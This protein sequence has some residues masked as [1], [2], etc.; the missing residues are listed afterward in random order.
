[1]DMRSP[2]F[3]PALV[4]GLLA[5]APGAAP[6]WNRPGH[7]VSAAI[8][9]QVLKADDP[10]TI[11]KAALLREHPYYER[12]W[13][14]RLEGVAPEDRDLVLFMEAARWPDDARNDEKFHH[15]EWHYV[16]LPFKP[17]GQPDR[18]RPAGPDPTNILWAFPRQLSAVK[19]DSAPAADRAVALAWVF[20]LVGDVHQ[21]LHAATLFTTDFP[22]G[23]RG[24]TRFY[25][26]A[27]EDKQVIN[28][29]QLWDDLV[30]GSNNPREV[31]NRA[32]E[33]R[34][35]PEFAR[36]RLKELAE[37][38]FD[39]WAAESFRLGKEVAYLNGELAGS[40][41]R[42]DAPVLPAGYT[43]KAQAVAERRVVLAG[44]RLAE[45]LKKSFE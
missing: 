6:A 3:R 38:A 18:V 43:K 5:L 31:K 7:M 21:P 44:Y 34:L 27:R 25:I 26:R 40:P 17:E 13:A 10:Q 2:C 9:Y 45:L 11:R 41:D 22:E 35:R 42:G 4:L 36:D 16:N 28:L 14:R 12:S 39:K 15:G 19:D 1:M 24:A 8:A 30:F 29:H 37:P 20:H 32:T 33:L 23:D